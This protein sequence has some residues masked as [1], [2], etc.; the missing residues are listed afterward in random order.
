MQ[1]KA[2]TKACEDIKAQARTVQHTTGTAK[3]QAIRKLQAV[4]LGKHDYYEKATQVSQD[5]GKVSY[6][7]NKVIRGRLKPVGVHWSKVAKWMRERYGKPRGG[8]LSVGGHIIPPIHRV[9]F[10]M[11]WPFSAKDIREKHTADLDT[12]TR[13]MLQS[14]SRGSTEYLNNKISR[15]L[16]QK[17]KCYITDKP[18]KANEAHAHHRRP[19]AKGGSDEY[20]N[21]VILHE[22]AHRLVHATKPETADMYAKH[23]AITKEQWAKVRKLRSE[24]EAS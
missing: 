22:E 19:K 18:I 15:Y 16:A 14:D 20:R 3:T 21:L 11:P 9:Q 7:V 2:I 4:I 24:L 13:N 10:E 8:Y 23:L 6:Q 5:R 12:E 17:G 1:G